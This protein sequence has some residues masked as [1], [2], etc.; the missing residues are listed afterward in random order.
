VLDHRHS[1]NKFQAIWPAT[2]KARQPNIERRWWGTYSWQ[3]ADAAVRSCQRP[4]CSI[5]SGRVELWT[6]DTGGRAL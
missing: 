6:A 3:T 1:G 5:P 4:E 2:E